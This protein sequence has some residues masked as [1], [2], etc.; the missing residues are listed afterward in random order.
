MV[1]CT[2]SAAPTSGSYRPSHILAPKPGVTNEFGGRKSDSTGSLQ[3]SQQCLSII[4]HYVQTLYVS[5]TSP[6]SPHGAGR[7]KRT[8]GIDSI[9]LES[10]SPVI[11]TCARRTGKTGYGSRRSPLGILA[12]GGPEQPLSDYLREILPGPRPPA[13]PPSG[14][15][16]LFFRIWTIL[17][18]MVL[19]ENPAQMR[20]IR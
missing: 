15:T 6:V 13:N 9:E 5:T 14:P 3:M 10:S 8:T 16:W 19:I 4:F 2:R 17:R 20:Q 18:I 11:S 12:T 7:R 1:G